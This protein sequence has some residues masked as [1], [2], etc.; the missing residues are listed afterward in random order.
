MLMMTARRWHSYIGAFIAPTVLFLAATGCLQVF[1]LHEAH[2]GYTPPVQIVSLSRI[3][4]DQ[5]YTLPP[6]K[7]AP[8]GAPEAS[9][10]HHHDG[11]AAAPAAKAAPKAPRAT[12][13]AVLALKWFFVLVGL[14]LIAST[15]LGLW[16]AFTVSR[17]RRLMIGLFAVGVVLPIALL[18]LEPR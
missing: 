4:K 12:P 9:H 2:G 6:A 8:S 5:V 10:E 18:A 17:N 14:A 11:D 7:G 16:M 1:S 15:L 13:W 3:H